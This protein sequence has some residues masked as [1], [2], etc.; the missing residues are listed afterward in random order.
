M[1]RPENERDYGQEAIEILLQ[2]MENHRDDLVV[3]LAGYKDR[4]DT[5]F[6]SNPGM[7]SRIAHHIDFPD[8]SE[9]ELT[10]I[11]GKMVGGMNYQLDADAE[12]AMQEYIHLRKQQPHFAN[13]R[14][15]RNALDRARLRQANRIFKIA[16]EGTATVTAH[17]LST[18]SADDL[19]TS[20]VFTGGLASDKK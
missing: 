5:F 15:I 17:E 8:Y 18:I 20:R 2:V 10:Q 4:M 12:K 13:A 11:A 1:Y 3:I 19:R 7:S 14:S 16:M 9:N 6:Q